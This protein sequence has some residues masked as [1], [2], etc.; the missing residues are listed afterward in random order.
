MVSEDLH[1]GLDARDNVRYALMNREKKG[2]YCLRRRSTNMVKSLG[3]RLVE[4]E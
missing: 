1:I 2:E 3:I 4:R